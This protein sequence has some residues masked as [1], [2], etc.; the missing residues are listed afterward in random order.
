M[1]P[2]RDHAAMAQRCID[3]ARRQIDLADRAISLHVRA[4]HIALADHYLRQA[5]KE[6]VASRRQRGAMTATERLAS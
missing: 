4:E 6:L 3:W 5:E 2:S 1:K